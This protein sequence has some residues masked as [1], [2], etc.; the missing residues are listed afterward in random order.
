MKKNLLR[1]ISIFTLC[2][3]YSLNFT[4]CAASGRMQ[5]VN[6]MDGIEATVVDDVTI[7]NK[8]VVSQMKFSLDMLK[9]TVSG[10]DNV[11]I[12][13]LSIMAALAMTANGAA[14]DTLSGMEAVIANN[15]GLEALN[16][17]LSVYMNGLPSDEKYSFK[18]ANSIW[19][20]D[21][22]ERLKVEQDFLQTNADY[23]GADVY[24]AAF[25]KQTL[26]DINNW[27]EENTDG[28][29]K[30]ILD[31]IDDDAVMYLVN[32]LA[33]EAEWRSKY[34]ADDVADGTFTTADGSRQ[35][36]SMMNSVEYSYLED[37]MAT[38]F[39]KSYQ[40]GYRFVA[41][42]P[43]EGVSIE[44]YVESLDEEALVSLINNAEA[45]QVK[46][47]IPKFSYEYDIELSEVLKNLGM[48]IAFDLGKA[49]F[50]K[51]AT[52]SRGNIGIG[53]VLH[54]TFIELNETGTKAGAATVVEM[55]DEAAMVIPDDVKTVILD[56]PFVYMIIEGEMG[57]PIFM[58]TV[59]NIE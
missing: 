55:I 46:T 36:A 42:L 5:A 44:E 6:L 1:K 29:I 50:S 9:Q 34:M 2:M 56:R 37:D 41:L 33:F 53:R 19:F 24:K 17:Y 57:L 48:E 27:V 39:I 51:M 12:S 4:A 14:G 20:R 45:T 21:D 58:G 35:K 32:A 30:D 8:F 18:L 25:D 16:E 26:D 54:K 49:D 15:L 13:P 43:N 3:I 7:D 10:D 11:L 23:Y 38:G 31:K 22:K 28:M 52:S 47:S 59:M 40:G